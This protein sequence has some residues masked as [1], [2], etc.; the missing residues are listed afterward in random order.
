MCACWWQRPRPQA[1][2]TPLASWS[3][4]QHFMRNSLLLLHL[5]SCCSWHA[6]RLSPYTSPLSVSRTRTGTLGVVCVKP[7]RHR[8]HSAVETQ[9]K[10][11]ISNS[12]SRCHGRNES[13]DGESLPAAK[14]LTSNSIARSGGQNQQAVAAAV[15]SGPALLTAQR[16]FQRGVEGRGGGHR[17][18]ENPSKLSPRAA[19]SGSKLPE[20]GRQRGSK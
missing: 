19:T 1:A 10:S 9:P 17:L 3:Q 6:R 12:S 8:R 15:G 2:Q 4:D 5:N 20:P 14:I 16:G 13:S 7:P 18:R 11:Q